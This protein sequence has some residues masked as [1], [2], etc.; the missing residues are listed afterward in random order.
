MIDAHPARPALS[1][2]QLLIRAVAQVF[3]IDEAALTGRSR[4]RQI[5]HARQAACYLLKARLPHLSY[6][7]IGR[8]LGGIDHSTVI[9]G[10]R[11]TAERLS[12]DPQLAGRIFALAHT[13]IDA[14]DYD[15]HV[16]QWR[17]WRRARAQIQALAGSVQPDLGEELAEFIAPDKVWCGQCDASVS[18]GVA[19]NCRSRFCG[20]KTSQRRAA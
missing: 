13:G 5:A 6:P 1:P 9:H 20:V 8:M 12:W 17:A 3:E 2:A 10:E 7:V 4:V 15:A 11:V 19:A 14:R 16:W 18:L